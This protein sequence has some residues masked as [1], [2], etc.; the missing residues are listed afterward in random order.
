MALLRALR[1][2][3]AASVLSTAVVSWLSH[4]RTR[5]PAAGTNATSQ[6]IWGRR[7]H[8][9]DGLSLAYTVVGYGIH[10]ACSVFWASGFEYVRRGRRT[11][12]RVVALAMAM[13]AV[14]Y[15]VDYR[16]V[17]PRLSPGFDRRLRHRDLFAVY[18][19]FGAGVALP[20]LLKRRSA[21]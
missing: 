6:W 8:R 12:G 18:A 19:A 13:A 21:R 1:S 14:A 10:H 5:A 16:V 15:V 11:P 4:R 3:A 7:A 2:G 9:Q 20:W 17:P